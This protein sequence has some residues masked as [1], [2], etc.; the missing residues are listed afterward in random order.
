MSGTEEERK[1]LE[2]FQKNI[3]RFFDELIEMFPNEKDF[4]LIRILVKDQIP[5]T[6]IMSYFE[7]V[8][9]NKE[10]ISSIEHRDDTFILSNVLFSKISNSTVF[11][12]LWEKHLDN[13]DKEMIWSWVD[14]FKLMTTEYMKLNGRL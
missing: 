3:V 11:K 8:M 4:I 13:D 7:M 12:N 1:L 2:R 10:I 14:C 5:S 6:Q 9:K